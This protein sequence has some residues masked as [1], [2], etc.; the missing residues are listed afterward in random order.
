[1]CSFFNTVILVGGLGS[2]IKVL[3]PNL[4]KPLIPVYNKPHLFFIISYFYKCGLRVFTLGVGFKSELFESFFSANKK[5]FNFS[6]SLILDS[7]WT[8]TGG[9]LISMSKYLNNKVSLVFN[10]D[11][12]FKPFFKGYV[13]SLLDGNV[14]LDVL[15]GNCAIPSNISSYGSILFKDEGQRVIRF[16]EKFKF[17]SYPSSV[18]TGLYVFKTKTFKSLI[19][20]YFINNKL[21]LNT[22]ISLERGLIPLILNKFTVAGGFYRGFFVDTGTPCRYRIK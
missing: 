4:P 8:G 21:L 13:S 9:A 2:R 14:F 7:G 22:D 11:S 5:L 3:F 19:N 16:L 10:G 15:L 6:T 17:K 12:F 18:N 1:M 20:S